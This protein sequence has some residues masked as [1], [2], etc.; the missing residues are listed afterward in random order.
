M[1]RFWTFL[2]FGPLFMFVVEFFYYLTVWSSSLHV[3]LVFVITY[4]VGAIPA[5][6]TW[7]VDECLSD[8]V[9]NSR[10]AVI[11]AIAGYVFVAG[12]VAVWAGHVDLNAATVGVVGAIAGLVCSLLS[13][14]AE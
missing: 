14:R 5:L 1:N 4:A 11:S 6:L 10:R 8:K 2:V 13:A 9:R 7:L 3:L 12:T